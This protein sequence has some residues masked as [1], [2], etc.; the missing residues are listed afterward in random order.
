MKKRKLQNYQKAVKKCVLDTTIYIVISSIKSSPQL[1]KRVHKTY[2]TEV[3]M[4][5]V[6]GRVVERGEKMRE[7]ERE[8]E[9]EMQRID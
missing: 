5:S 4:Y 2:S 7:R 1:H 9:K 3:W 6:R 8:R